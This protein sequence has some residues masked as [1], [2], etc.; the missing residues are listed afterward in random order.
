MY[1]WFERL[2]AP[3]A[4]KIITVSD[5]DRKLAIARRIAPDD[6]LVTIHNG[7]PDIAPALR[8]DP[9]RSPVRLVMI[10]RFEPQ[11]DHATL[12]HALAGLKHENWHLDLIGDGPLLPQARELTQ[13]LGL[14][15]RVQFWGQRLDVAARLAEAQ[16]ALLITKWEGFPRSI[17]EAMRA[18]LPVIASAVGGVAESVVDG[19]TGWTVGREDVAGVQGRLTQLLENPVLRHR[20]GRRARERY[21]REFMLARTVTRTLA[22]YHEILSPSEVAPIRQA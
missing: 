15:E 5:F 16:V 12:L 19:E 11:K 10:A 2:A 13:Q 4:L 6:Q 14:A 3:L 21:E 8:A 22:V 9:T 17:L 18:G 7:M 1:G 20:M